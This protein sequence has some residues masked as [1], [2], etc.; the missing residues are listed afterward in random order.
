V[1]GALARRAR[2]S[3]R[4]LSAAPPL[5]A[6]SR[7]PGLPAPRAG[8]SRGAAAPRL[9]AG[10]GARAHPPAARAAV[11]RLI[12]CEARRAWASREFFA[13]WDPRALDLYAQ[14]GLRDRA[15]GQVELKC[16]PEVEATVFE[17]SGA[18]DIF[19][20]APAVTAPT[21]FLWASRGDFPRDVHEALAQRMPHARVEAVEA[22]HLIPMERPDLVSEA[23]LR[24]ARERV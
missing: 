16:A 9:A 6:A 11:A 8:G 18:F 17:A 22:G 13:A 14:E 2:P 1:A 20:L 7:T 5:A 23:V 12:P 21:L 19:T 4:L 24:F 10:G 15:D 3:P